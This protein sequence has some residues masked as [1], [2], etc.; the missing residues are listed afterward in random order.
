KNGDVTRMVHASITLAGRL[1]P[2]D[3]E[4]ALKSME[5]IYA[6]WLYA[7]KSTDAQWWERSS[8]RTWLRYINMGRHYGIPVSLEAL[9][10]FRATLIRLSCGSIIPWTPFANSNPTIESS[11]RKPEGACA[12]RREKDCTAPR[13]WTT[14]AS[15]ASPTWALNFS[16]GSNARH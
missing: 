15:K 1:F 2:M 10:F 16:F 8:A 14:S 3:V 13:T 4:R 11:A 5:R 6:D 7:I 9:H 12:G